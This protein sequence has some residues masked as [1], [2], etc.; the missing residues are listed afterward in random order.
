MKKILFALLLTIVFLS[1]PPGCK[2]SGS[3]ADTTG[4]GVIQHDNIVMLVP[5]NWNPPLAFSYSDH[6]I[7]S[8]QPWGG[9]TAGIQD[10]FFTITAKAGRHSSSEVASWF[11]NHCSV[12]TCSADCSGSWPDGLNFAFTGTVTINGDSYPVTLGQGSTLGKNN[13]WIG[14]PGYTTHQGGTYN[15]S[16]PDKR[17][18]FE[19]IENTTDQI[20]VKTS[21]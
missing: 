5:W 20:W 18:Y 13:W 6:S 14:G 15:V 3:S 19:P 11:K 21:Y 17:Y 1:V 10:G 2:K 8:G 4:E 9:V 16:T 12:A 7:T